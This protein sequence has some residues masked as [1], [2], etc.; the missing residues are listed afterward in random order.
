MWHPCVNLRC[1]SENARSPATAPGLSRVIKRARLEV[2]S[3]LLEDSH[4]APTRYCLLCTAGCTRCTTVR[5]VL[6]GF[7]GFFF[8]WQIFFTCYVQGGTEVTTTGWPSMAQLLQNLKK[9]DWH[10]WKEGIMNPFK[11][12]EIRILSRSKMT[13]VFHGF[14]IFPLCSPTQQHGERLP[15]CPV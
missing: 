9:M 15:K 7:A 14:S 6:L 5:S 12:R 11:N 3:R 4:S 1:D 2:K 8:A 13:V 10:Q